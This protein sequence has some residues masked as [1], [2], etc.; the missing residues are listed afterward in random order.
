MEEIQSDEIYANDIVKPYNQL[1][2]QY[3]LIDTAWGKETPKDLYDKLT[4]GGTNIWGLLGYFGRD[5]R[6]GNIDATKEAYCDYHLNLAG[7]LLRTGNVNSFITVLAKVAS[8]LELSQSLGGF[9]RKRLGTFTKE[10]HN[11]NSEQ[12]KPLFEQRGQ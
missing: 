7:D 9:L 4:V 12:K 6:L 10:S 2:L 5:L 8:T 1:E 3:T 11:T